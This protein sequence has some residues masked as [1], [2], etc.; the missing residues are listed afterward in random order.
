MSARGDVPLRV[1]ASGFDNRSLMALQLFFRA[2]CAGLAV[3]VDEGEAEVGIIDMDSYNAGKVFA[4][5]REKFPARPMI[6]LS[7]DAERMASHDRAVAVRKPVQIQSMLAA[8]EKVQT[9]FLPHPEIPQKPGVGVSKPGDSP[10]PA[11]SVRTNLEDADRQ[12]RLEPVQVSPSATPQPA[13]Q[14]GGGKPTHEAPVKAAP[15]LRLESRTASQAATLLDEKGFEQYIGSLRNIDP[16]NPVEVKSAQYD[17]KRYLQG[18]LQA[19]C[20]LAMEKKCAIRLNTGWKSITIFPQSGEILIE[21][22]E[23]Q[24]RAFCLVPVHSISDLDFADTDGGVMTIVQVGGHKLPERGEGSFDR[25][26][27]LIWKVALWTSAGRIPDDID[28]NSPVTLRQWPNFTRLLVFPHAMRIAAVMC[29]RPR[30]LLNIAEI[31]GIKQQ[32]V[33]AFFSAARALGLAE[34]AAKES[35]TATVSSAM[36]PKKNTGLLRKILQRLL[37][38]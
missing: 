2:K 24:L 27:A 4:E 21:A 35:T 3:L 30:T 9:F 23:Q 8:L 20:K 31:L 26:D 37:R 25:I 11:A 36:E 7:L 14:G 38:R 32:Y 34:Q 28:L 1:C 15:S 5:Q 10:K 29:E 19:A 6:L 22:D 12:A 18:Y 16:K 33:F 17:P 13:V